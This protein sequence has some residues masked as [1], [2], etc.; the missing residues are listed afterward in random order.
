MTRWQ[1]IITPLIILKMRLIKS[2]GFAVNGIKF[3]LQEPNFKI[4]LGFAL[5][6][7]LLGFILNISLAEWAL[8]ALC[9]GLVLALE[10]INTAIEQLCNI[11]YPGFNPL[12]KMV[13]DVSAAA[14]LVVAIAAAICGFIIFIP[15]IITGFQNI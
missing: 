2:F 10:M 7:T 6:A 13:K 1:I 15:K 3:C 14:V 4:H 9:I 11:V 5:L 8:V 12:I